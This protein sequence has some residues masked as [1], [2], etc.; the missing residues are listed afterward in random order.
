MRNILRYMWKILAAHVVMVA[1]S[2]GNSY[3]KV[4]TQC[5]C[6]PQIKDVRAYCSEMS[7]I[8]LIDFS[9]IVHVNSTHITASYNIINKH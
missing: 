2:E 7:D 3:T 1:Q 5:N 8:L 4:F 6:T 9:I